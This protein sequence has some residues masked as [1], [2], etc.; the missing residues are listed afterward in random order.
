MK[1]EVDFREI[2]PQDLVDMGEKAVKTMVERIA[3]HVIWG[4]EKEVSVLWFDNYKGEYV[5]IEDG[6]QL[7]E[8]IDRQ[9]GWSSKQ[10]MFFA[11]LVDLNDDSKVGY[12]PSQLA[13]QMT[14]DQWA[15][16][17]RIV[18]ICTELSVI[19]PAVRVDWNVVELSEPT[20]LVIAPMADTEMAK[21]FGIPVDER[22]EERGEP[23]LADSVLP[24]D[25]D[26][27]LMEDAA[28]DVDDAHDDELVHVYDKENPIIQVGKMWPSMDEFRMCF[29][30]YAVK[31]QFDAKTL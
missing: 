8:E 17:R 31:H 7:V 19:A 9:D 26:G 16:Q 2:D 22:D 20:D 29:K 24:E 25:I 4:P 23:I 14:D 28:D 11:E 6:E 10:A 30:T 12:V 27:Q 15:A 1:W 3:E 5:R 21:L 13:M 18:P